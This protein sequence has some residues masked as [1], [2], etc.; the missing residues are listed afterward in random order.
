AKH[1]LYNHGKT[2]AE[3]SKELIE[4][5]RKAQRFVIDGST[6][7]LKVYF[8]GQPAGLGSYDGTDGTLLNPPPMTSLG[9]GVKTDNTGTMADPGSCCPG[10]WPYAL[11]DDLCRI[12]GQRHDPCVLDMFIAAVRFME[13]EPKKPW[14]KYTAE[15]KRELAVRRSGKN[16]PGLL[17]QAERR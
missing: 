5:L 11:Y 4:S 17:A 2:V 16:G 13:G 1:V 14:W 3:T 8:N 15:C 7:E 12:T 6:G 10:Y 9:I